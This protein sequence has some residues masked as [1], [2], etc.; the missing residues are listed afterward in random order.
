M[1]SYETHAHTY[2]CTNLRTP[3]SYTSTYIQ[4]IDAYTHDHFFLITLIIP[5]LFIYFGKIFRGKKKFNFYL[6]Y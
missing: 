1:C 5:F 3:K 6:H 4:Y 2:T